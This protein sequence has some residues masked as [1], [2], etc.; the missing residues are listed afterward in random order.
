MLRTERSLIWTHTLTVLT[1]QLAAVLSGVVDTIV[2]GR[3][4]NEALAALSVASALNISVIVSLIGVLN[5]L[6]PIYAEHRGAGRHHDVGKTLHQGIYLAMGLSIIAFLILM[7]PGWLL[8][9][10][11]VPPHL[12]PDIERYLAIQAFMVPL[13]MLFRMYAALNQ[14]LGK[15]WFVTWLQVGILLLKI[16]LSFAFIHYLGL[17]GCALASLIV[18]AAGLGIGVYLIASH[19][20]YQ[21]FAIWRAL[22]APNWKAIG[23]HLRL[24]IPAGLSQLVEITSFTLI[25]LL[26]ARLGVTASAAHQ[27]AG[28]M[29]AMVFMLPISYGV[30]AT[31]RVS[32]WIGHGNPQLAAQLIRQTLSWGLVFSCTLGATL[33]LTRHWL[34]TLFSSN[35]DVVALASTL[36]AFVAFYHV[37][38]SLQIM[39]MF[40][41]RCYRITLMPLIVYSIFLWGIGL[42]GGYYLAYGNNNTIFAQTPNAFWL[43]A[44]LSLGIV[45]AW[46]S[47]ALLKVS[48]RKAI[49]LCQTQS[50]KVSA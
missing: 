25:A 22:D 12:I 11:Q 23:R 46:F 8:T 50:T 49:L 24:G 40:L 26:V 39:G 3:Y 6:L 14:A 48:Q 33:L 2:A 9:L 18:T 13:F 19:A 10:S 16:P 35:P 30:A 32:Y 47:M 43:T 1:G 38:D 41:L 21:P 37:P 17:A 28:T 15:P 45:A 5:V 7:F 27:I 34:A 36:L 44:I 42:G 20:D 29:A 31:A 4:S